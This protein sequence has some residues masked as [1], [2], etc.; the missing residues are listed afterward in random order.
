MQK[1]LFVCC[2]FTLIT[3]DAV[4]PALLNKRLNEVSF[5]QS[6]NA[7]SNKKSQAQ[8]QD[9]TISQQLA[10]GIRSIKIPIH[11][12]YANAMGFY[13]DILM[14]ARDDI[15]KKLRKTHNVF[16]K[17]NLKIQL[18]SI[19]A[20]LK[21]IGSKSAKESRQRILFACH[22]M[23]K[24]KIYLKNIADS[25]PKEI[26]PLLKIVETVLN[27]IIEGTLG[28]IDE[29]GGIIPFTP[30][31]LDA[32][33]TPLIKVLQE[34]NT[35]LKDN[36][37][38][39]FILKIEEFTYQDF[40]NIAQ[41]FEKSGILTFAHVQNPNEPWPTLGDMI[42]SGK[43]LVVLNYKKL[44]TKYPG[45]SQY[46]DLQK[47]YPWSNLYIDY[48]KWGAQWNYKSVKNLLDADIEP[49]K[50]FSDPDYRDNQPPYNK[51]LTIHHVVTPIMAGDINVAKQVNAFN[52]LYPRAQRLAKIVD[53]IPNFISVDFY[54]Y[55]NFDVFKVQNALNGI[56]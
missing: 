55:P 11:Y 21:I 47:R 28:E 3:I 29:A 22:A 40:K 45:Q 51:L 1:V 16:K 39:I 54:E 33:K 24:Q 20:A 15:E 53:H 42:K 5:I 46:K 34:I 41:E 18:A 14:I 30:C 36:P 26:K 49:Q 52:N 9:R 4:H 17:S 48:D 13:Y 12:D 10:D 56:S 25:A 23:P 19:N 35:F 8:N 27:K 43:R 37:E 6:H 31:V 44:S 32:G 2:L 7:S 50:E 38:E